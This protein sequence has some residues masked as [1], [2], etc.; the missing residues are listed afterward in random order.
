MP[1]PQLG[2]QG[3]EREQIWVEGG[4]PGLAGRGLATGGFGACCRAPVDRRSA[5]PRA[6]LL[7]R[8]GAPGKAVMSQCPRIPL[9]G[10]VDEHREKSGGQPTWDLPPEDNR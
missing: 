1:V 6:D 10:T 8:F 5:A 7:G 4:G 2:E 9:D 3:E